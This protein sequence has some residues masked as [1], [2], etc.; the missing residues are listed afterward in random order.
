[1]SEFIKITDDNQELM[2]FGVKGMRWGHTKTGYRSTGIRSALARRANDNVDSGFK[3][4]QINAQKKQTAIDAGKKR[5]EARMLYESNR[6][7][8]Q[9]KAD[10]KQADKE[11]KK[12]LGKNTT[13]RKGDVKNEVGKD[14]SRKYLSE[15]KQLKKQIDQGFGDAKTK[16][17]YQDLMNQYDIERASARRAPEVAAKR[18]R[19]KASMKRAM[20]MAVKTAVATAAVT[21]GS[22]YINNRLVAEGKQPVDIPRILDFAKKAKD[23][24][25]Y[26]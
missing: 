17:R 18:S 25:G 26:F 11:Y 4:W 24:A 21:A 22:R 15:A 5:N 12:A 16:K 23:F 14:L 2:H 3:D 9:F 6:G 7:S 19:K 1:M 13:Y 8:K 20:T 10:Y